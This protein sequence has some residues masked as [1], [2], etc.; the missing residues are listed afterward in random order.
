MPAPRR[1]R[2]YEYLSDAELHERMG[3]CIL[4]WLLARSHGIDVV[5]QEQ[6]EIGRGLVSEHLLR[7][8]D[9]DTGQPLLPPRRL[10]YCTR[11]DTREPA[12]VAACV[13][14]TC[15]LFARQDRNR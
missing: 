13:D 4:D 2:R 6:R 9:P 14:D 11:C 8:L 12:A 5:E 7:G 1:Q 15:P 3:L 10:A